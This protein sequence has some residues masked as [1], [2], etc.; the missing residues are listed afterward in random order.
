MHCRPTADPEHSLPAAHLQ[1]LD[2]V[3]VNIVSLGK[4]SGTGSGGDHA[5][6][7]ADV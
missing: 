2:P 6:S 7:N 1:D 5:G 4:H 3:A